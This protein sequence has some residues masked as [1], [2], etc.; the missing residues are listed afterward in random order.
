M[1]NRE[2]EKRAHRAHRRHIWAVIFGFL[3]VVLLQRAIWDMTA[4][5][6]SPTATLLFG[7]IFVGIVALLEKEYVKELF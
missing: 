7:L 2:E 6:L 5:I 1:N 3:A 4:E